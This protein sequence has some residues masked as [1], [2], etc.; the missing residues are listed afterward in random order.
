M[1]TKKTV[2]ALICSMPFL[3][4]CTSMQTA[5]NETENWRINP[6]YSVNNSSQSANSLYQ[7]GRYYQGQQRYAQ[8]LTTYRATLKP[9]MAAV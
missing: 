6:L 8:A 4:S 1:K 3:A 9:T 7:L 2:F 5:S